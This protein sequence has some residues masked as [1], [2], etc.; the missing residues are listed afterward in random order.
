MAVPLLRHGQLLGVLAFISSTAARRYGQGDLRLAEALAERAAIAIE[1]ARLYR[2]SVQAAQVRD[3]VLGFVAHDLRNPLGAISM[4]A[5]LLR[6]REGE[7]ERRSRKPADT[8]QRAATRMNRLIQ[9]ILDV[10]RMEG[11]HLSVEPARVPAGQLVFDS[12]EAQRPLACFGIL[13][14]FKLTWQRAFPMSGPI[15][16]EFSRCSRT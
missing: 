16:T 9:D 11:G 8:I 12:V 1:N 7:P 14:I 5:S 13:L 10:S 4:Q 3:Q 2:A 15:A 6:R